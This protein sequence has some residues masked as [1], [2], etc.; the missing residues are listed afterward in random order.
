MNYPSSLYLV[1]KSGCLAIDSY[2]FHLLGVSSPFNSPLFWIALLVVECFVYRLYCKFL[3][4]AN[5][6][7]L[8]PDEKSTL[9]SSSISCA[10][11]LA[12]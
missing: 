10:T 3:T 4:L 6:D 9:I 12:I 8:F 11:S 5:F 1:E 2:S 7:P